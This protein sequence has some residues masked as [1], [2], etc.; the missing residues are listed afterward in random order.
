MKQF[1]LENVETELDKIKNYPLT[2]ES[3]KLYVLLSRVKKYMKCEEHH[4][5]TNEEAAAWVKHMT[6]AA[7]WTM[8]QTTAVM[9]QKGY[10]HNTCEFYAVMNSLASDYGKTMAKYGADKPEIWA[11]LAN[12]WLNDADAKDGKAA[13][14]YTE[15]V[16]H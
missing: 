1:T 3:A 8:D 11:E 5:L 6:P 13:A 12:D 2:Q 14:Y 15:I 16:K 10:S 7:R 9:Q 4:A